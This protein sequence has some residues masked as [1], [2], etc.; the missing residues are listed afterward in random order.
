MEFLAFMEQTFPDTRFESV[1]TPGQGPARALDASP[2]DEKNPSALFPEKL[3]RFS[4]ETGD[5]PRPSPVTNVRLLRILT[6]TGWM[7]QPQASREDGYITR[8][9]AGVLV[10]FSL[11]DDHLRVEVPWNSR[12]EKREVQPQSLRATLRAVTGWNVDSRLLTMIVEPDDDAPGDLQVKRPV[13]VVAY[14]IWCLAAGVND[15]QF[16]ELVVEAAGEAEEFIRYCRSSFMKEEEDDGA[17]A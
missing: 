15:R 5:G 6:G 1:K 17:G 9:D 16:T 8:T 4:L 10:G 2:R 13:R 14:G 7:V 11:A 3:T 12:V